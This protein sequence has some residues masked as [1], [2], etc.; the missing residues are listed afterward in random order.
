[1]KIKQKGHRM[2]KKTIEN[3]L[4]NLQMKMATFKRTINEDL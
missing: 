4:I 2:C 3:N 1:M